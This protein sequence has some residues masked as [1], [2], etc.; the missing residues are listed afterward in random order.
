M[1]NR[2]HIVSRQE[3]LTDDAVYFADK[4]DIYLNIKEDISINL[5]IPLSMVRICGS[6][7]WGKSY[8]TEI[9]FRPG[10]SDLD[11]AVISEAL[12]V[13]CISEVRQITWNFSN[14]TSFSSG[15]RGPLTFQEYAYKKG[16]VRTDLM[17][18]THTKKRLDI[19]SDQISRKYS[20]HFSKITFLV[21]DSE[22]SFTVKQI[23]PIAKFRNVI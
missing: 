5:S 6:A 3:F 9:D 18:R 10:E 16:I 13:R 20:S 23:L 15:P 4:K 12:Y 8:S 22:T 2:Q 11:V 17:P 7:Y 21:Y 14:L 19:A 1:S